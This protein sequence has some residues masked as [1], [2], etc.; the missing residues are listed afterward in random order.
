M[1]TPQ[2]FLILFY[3]FLVILNYRGYAK[4]R[5]TVL[6]TVITTAVSLFMLFSTNTADLDWEVTMLDMSGYRMDYE[7]YDA[8][9]HSDFNMYYLFFYSMHIGQF[10]GW[11]FRFWWAIM[12]IL[13]MSVIFCACKIHKYNF[14]LFLATFMAYYE[15]VFFSGLKFFYGFCFLLLAYGFLLKNTFKGRLFFIVFLCIAGGFHVMYY[16]FLLLL[17]QPR[18]RPKLFVTIVVFAS[19]FITALMR[20]SGSA[21]G[22][23]SPIID[24]FKSDHLDYYI[25]GTVHLG[26]YLALF[27]HLVV[28]FIAYI[29]RSYHIK[30]GTSSPT[31][32]TLYYS[33]L[34]SLLFCP[35]Y[36]VALTFMRFITAFS[37]VVIAAGSSVMSDSCPSRSLYTKLSLF[38]V[39][40]YHLIRIVSSFGVPRSFYETSVMPFFDVF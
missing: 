17:L 22:F 28:V 6:L 9:E 16:F 11:S 14:N 39:A 35:L 2:F 10:L 20:V 18:K 7:L 27:V 21:V 29:I 38:M 5:A 32:D 4:N 36:G 23:L 34:V 13:A 26:F 24:I 8:L 25:A 1:T 15:M 31:V 37:L 3:L 30:K 12:S 40:S 19:F 33:V